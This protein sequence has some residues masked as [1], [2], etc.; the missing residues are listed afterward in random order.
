MVDETIEDNSLKSDK[1]AEAIEHEE[2]FASMFEKSGDM[3]WRLEPGQKV[4]STVISISGDLAYI[5]LGGKSEGAIDVSEFRDEEGTYHL[6]VGDEVEAFFLSVQNGLK[7]LTTLI[8]GQ[9]S[10]HL[11][12]IRSAYSANVPVN[13]DIKREV[14]GGFEVAVGGLRCFC[15]FSQIDLKGG[16]EGGIY[17]GQTFPFKILKY[18]DDGRNIIVSRRALLEEEQK[19][20]IDK[21]KENLCVGMDVAVIVRS[22]QKF[23][24]FVDLGGIDGLIPVSEMSWARTEDP[25]DV[26]SMGQVV[27]A[28]ILSLDWDNNRLTLSIKALQPDPWDSIAK[29]YTVDSRVSG[30]IVRLAPFGAFMRLEPGVDG[31]IHIS[32]LGAGRRINHPRE[33]VEIGQWVEAYVISVDPHNKKISLSIQPKPKPEKIILPTVGEIVQ[34][35]VE[36][37]M[38]FGVFVKLS[39]GATGLIPN[40]EAGTPRGTDHHH[41]FPIGMTLPVVV[42]EADTGSGKVS[43]S[44]KSVM[45]KQEQEEFNR[46]QDSAKNEDASSGS[47]GRLGELLKAKM[48]EKNLTFPRR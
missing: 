31:L 12:A 40:S 37:V 5:D 28:R 20:R 6:K 13:G 4:K 25:A 7:K 26:L 18:E 1:D 39:G 36:K 9:S 10:V 14:K 15:P 30:T 43:L 48:E 29:N 45:E 41:L 2:S 16:R 46:Y 32:N 22:L 21:L 17:L 42:I 11:N 38:P 47:V 19:I 34:G 33:V 24:A 8:H 44:R 3:D 23:G 27:T 35:T